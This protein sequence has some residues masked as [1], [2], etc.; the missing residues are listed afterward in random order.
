MAAATTA[1]PGPMARPANS[2]S[3]TN[4]SLNQQTKNSDETVNHCSTSESTTINVND[5]RNSHVETSTKEGITPPGKAEE[6]A[7]PKVDL[8][9]FDNKTFVEAPL[10]KTNPWTRGKASGPSQVAEKPKGKIV[11]FAG[12]FLICHIVKFRCMCIFVPD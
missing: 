8:K 6:K 9:I 12:E 10:P 3:D 7:V 4:N 1:P 2:V 11:N 5:V